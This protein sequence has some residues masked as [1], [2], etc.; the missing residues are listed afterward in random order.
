MVPRMSVTDVAWDLE[1]LVSGEGEAGADRLLEEAAERTAIFA[2]RYAGRVAELD[3]H[4]LA[5]AVAELQEIS[6]LSGRDGNFAAL[7]FSVDTQDPANGALLQRV[8]ERVARLE[9][10]LVFF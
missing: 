8:Q 4:G 10:Q 2:E 9:T 3:G 1:P 7:R 5:E 6:D